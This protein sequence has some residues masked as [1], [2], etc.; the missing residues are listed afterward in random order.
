MVILMFGTQ[1]VREPARAGSFYPADAATLSSDV[2][3][4]F[5]KAGTSAVDGHVLAL[6]APHAGYPFSGATAGKA[7]A[8]VRGKDYTR[9]IL[10]GTGHAAY[11]E[12]GAVLAD[13]QSWAMPGGITPVDVKAVQAL[14]AKPG[15]KISNKMHTGEHSLEVQLP[16]LQAALKRF[17]IIPFVM[18][19]QTTPED[20]VAIAQGLKPYLD[21]KTLVVVSSDFTHYGPNY[22]YIPFRDDVPNKLKALDMAVWDLVRPGDPFAFDAFLQ[23]TEAT[24]CGERALMV[25]C[26]LLPSEAKKQFIAYTSSGEVL[27]D[28]E[29]SVGYLAGAFTGKWGDTTALPPVKQHSG[30]LTSDEKKQLVRLARATLRSHVLS[31]DS[32]SRFLTGMK[33]SEGMTGISGAFVTYKIH[34]DLRGCIGSIEGR[35]PLWLAVVHNACNAASH[36][37]RFNAVGPS[38]VDAIHLEVSVLTPL[39]PAASYQEIKL[40][41][42]GVLLEKGGRGAV[43]LPQVATETGWSLDEFLS[44]LAQKAGLRADD[45]KQ[46]ATFKL[47]EAIVIEE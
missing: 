36:D 30:V 29:N 46:G 2:Q 41:K 35:E 10:L 40:G 32:L 18:G 6:V 27:H 13:W 23:T 3:G 45:W 47:F 9:V 31:D 14:S 22:Q 5:Q 38:E 33:F 17:T 7:Y 1:S 24:V 4:F 43:F 8:A 20:A 39:K 16:F 44:H 34:D 21:E 11:N 19:G 26:A 25:L 42:H 37:P 28:Y 12:R 15:F